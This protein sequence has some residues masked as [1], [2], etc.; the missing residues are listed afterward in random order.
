[1]EPHYSLV[2]PDGLNF[3][4][5]T[6]GDH[7]ALRMGTLFGV[8]STLSHTTPFVYIFTSF[9]PFFSFLLSPLFLNSSHP[10]GGVGH[11]SLNASSPLF[12]I[13]VIL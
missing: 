2:E 9:L 11:S 13:P 5:G 4:S 1:V 12:V 10:L 8:Y 7:T 6:T 3:L